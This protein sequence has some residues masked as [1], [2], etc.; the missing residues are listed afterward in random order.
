MMDA[1]GPSERQLPDWDDLAPD[2]SR[3]RVL[4]RVDGASTAHFELGPHQVSRAVVHR[5]VEEIWYVLDGHGVM[6]R[7]LNGC[8]METKL[9]PGLSPTL[10][11]G[12][13]FQFHNVGSQALT[14][15]GVTVPPWPG[16]GEAI[17]VAGP[18]EPSV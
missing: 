10:P 11:V 17:P 16:D 18:W 9:E 5:T 1:T 12:T 8:A 6:W 7:E 13:R 15:L 14:V 3:V 2:G 4:R